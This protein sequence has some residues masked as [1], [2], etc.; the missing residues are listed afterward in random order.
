MRMAWMMMM[1]MTRVGGQ[2]ASSRA[3][4]SASDHKV[5]SSHENEM[6]REARRCE[7]GK[8]VGG[9]IS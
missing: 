4:S 6:M 9:K 8:M 5:T 2:M 3:V 7:W 1:M